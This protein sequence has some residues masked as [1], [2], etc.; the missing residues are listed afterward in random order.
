ML[1]SGKAP[2]QSV[3]YLNELRALDVLFRDGAMSRADL[4]R[5]LGLNRS[6][7]GSIVNTLLAESLV[8]ERKHDRPPEPRAQTGRPGIDVQLIRKAR[9]SSAPA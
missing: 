8:I 5:A 9:C 2:S 4:A 1:D 6:T 3:R 7:T